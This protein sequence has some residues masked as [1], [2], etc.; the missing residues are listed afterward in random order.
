MPS[1]HRQVKRPSVGIFPHR[2]FPSPRI[3]ATSAGRYILSPT[4]RFYEFARQRANL[5]IDLQK[6]KF[7]FE[8]RFQ[9]ILFGSAPNY[10]FSMKM[11]NF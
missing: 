2:R 11:W 9:I 4:S 8:M 3:R 7:Q 10:L 6:L 1:A 5:E